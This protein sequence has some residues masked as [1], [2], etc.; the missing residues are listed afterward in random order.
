MSPW[1]APPDPED[2]DSWWDVLAASPFGDIAIFAAVCVVGGVLI[3][4]MRRIPFI[5]L[6]AGIAAVVLL[7]FVGSRKAV[8]A[9]RKWSPRTYV[10]VS[11]LAFVGLALGAGLV[12]V[13]WVMVCDC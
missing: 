4:A 8:R 9:D 1:D 13:L 2:D 10:L 6:V 5:V 11:A 7:V 3:V 12:Y